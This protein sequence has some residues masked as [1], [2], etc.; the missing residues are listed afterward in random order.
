MKFSAF[1][2]CY[3][4]YNKRLGFSI[5]G[6]GSISHGDTRVSSIRYSIFQASQVILL[7]R[8]ATQ[9]EYP[10]HHVAPGMNKEKEI[11]ENFDNFLQIW[12]Y[13]LNFV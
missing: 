1:F 12:I 7:A 5:S 4:A 2:H 13:F 3:Y 8:N 10:F 6:S 11:K 9:G